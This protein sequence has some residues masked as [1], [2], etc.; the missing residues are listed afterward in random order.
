L[1]GTQAAY[2]ARIPKNHMTRMPA[3][4]EAAYKL[5]TSITL[6][7]GR[8]VSGEPAATNFSRAAAL[9]PPIELDE[10]LDL[11][12]GGQISDLLISSLLVPVHDL[13]G[14]PGKRL[15]AQLVKIG[16]DMALQADSR[17]RVSPRARRLSEEFVELIHAGTLVIDDIED[18]SQ[19]RRGKPALHCQ[20]GLPLALNAG[21]WLYFWP[22]QLIRR[23]G[24]PRERELLLYRYYHRVLVQAHCGQALDLGTDL[25]LLEQQ[26]V[27]GVCLAIMELKTGALAALALVMGAI[28][29]GATPAYIEAL[30]KYGRA[31]GVGLQMC[32]DLG[33]LTS[34]ADPAK[35]FEDL[36]LRRASW[37]VAFA[38]QHCTGREYEGFVSAVAKLPVVA[39]LECWLE[40]QDFLRIGKARVRQFLAE[41]TRSLTVESRR[42]GKAVVC[43]RLEALS[44]AILSGYD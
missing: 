6:E 15:R 4:T 3:P 30:D 21:N 9:P 43:H 24:L 17:F 5:K 35:R 34:K 14:R 10:L 44:D 19:H 39:P 1:N 37:A 38:A 40:Q 26:R 27:P 13:I 12:I 25:Y 36:K 8:A 18:G 23:M 31:F 2:A 33:N 28:V 41:S 29:S 7:K 42:M 16:F 11:K 32:D 22:T 20:Y